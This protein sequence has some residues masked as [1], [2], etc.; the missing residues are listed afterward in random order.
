MFKFMSKKGITFTLSAVLMMGSLVGCGAKT[1]T[2]NAASAT[3]AASAAASAAPTKT[4]LSGT[5]TASGSS[6]LL[7][8]VKQ[9]ATE[10]MEKNPKVTINVT[11]GG[12]GTGIKNVAD[13][14][15][16]IGNSDV[17]PAA[18]YKD[19]DL[20]D[21]VVAI[22][23]FALIVNKDVKV[24]NLTKQQ[25]ADIYMGKVTNWKEVGGNDAKIVLVHRPDS[26]GSRTLVKQIILDGK[27]FTKDG[28]TQEN[29]GAMKTAVAGQSG[30][31]GYVDTPYIDD[32]V[33]ALKIDSVAFS[34]DNI[35][36]G[37]YKL[38]GVEHMYTKGEAKDPAKAFIAYISSKEFQGK[39]VRDL[40]FLPADLLKK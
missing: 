14:T 28:I 20:K 38:F 5:V 37:T 26:S 18:E 4:E 6:A 39:Q 29:S 21:H 34:E 1:D 12:S 11:A 30:S 19:K 33:K 16:D 10:F 40:K 9:A 8:L 17:E 31:I 32:T 36:N 24:D 35:K 25:A 23:P 7:P 22:A 27:E 2:K 13:G 3:P 15:S